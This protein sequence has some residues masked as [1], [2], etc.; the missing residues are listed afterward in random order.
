VYT[1]VLHLDIATRAILG[2]RPGTNPHRIR[3]F[4]R[5]DNLVRLSLPVTFKRDVTS[6]KYITGK[7]LT[8]A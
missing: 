8:D 4:R 3:L 1:I 6:R 2:C 7:R 5:I